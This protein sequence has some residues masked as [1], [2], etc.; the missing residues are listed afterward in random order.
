MKRGGEKRP[1]QAVSTASRA[2]T[3]GN[4]D[5]KQTIFDTMRIHLLAL[6]HVLDASLGISL[7]LFQTANSLLQAQALPPAFQVELV[8][9]CAGVCT[10]GAGL[11]LQISHPARALPAPDLVLLPGSY[12]PS[13]K[14]MDLWLGSAEV[15]DTCNYLAD[16][17]CVTGAATPASCQIAAS[18][19]STFVL[20]QAG[21][22][23]GRQ[24]TTIWWLSRSFRQRYPAVQLD[25]QRM[26]VQDGPITTAGAALAQGD[27]VMQVIARHAGAQ[28]AHTC[29]RY[30]MMD[31][32]GSQ[33]RYAMVQHLAVQDPQLRQAEL[34]VRARLHQSLRI[35]DMADALHLTPRTLARRFEAALGLTPLQFV[36]RLRT[37]HALQLLQTTTQSMEAIAPQVG[38]A[39]SNALRRLLHREAGVTP[40]Q[41]RKPFRRSTVN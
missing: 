22:L 27:L 17:S 39:D 19:A 7:S 3:I 21:L 28:L 33:A 4:N 13:P 20:A 10:T 12:L 31:A 18:C 36:Q 24:A 23:Q 6:P 14:D 29:A 34:W 2:P 30:L 40:D 35:P 16:L 15:Q 26:V 37:E 5:K 1:T 25:M 9:P 8:S 38:Y 11:A 41:W 32:R